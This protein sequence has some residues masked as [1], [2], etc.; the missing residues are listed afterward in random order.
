MK[1]GERKAAKN[2]SVVSIIAQETKDIFEGALELG[3]S[4]YESLMGLVRQML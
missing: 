2:P 1:F 3:R 4:F